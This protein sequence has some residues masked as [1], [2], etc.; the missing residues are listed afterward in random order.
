MG[1]EGEDMGEAGSQFERSG[2]E[3]IVKLEEPAGREDL[4]SV[5]Y[6]NVS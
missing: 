5:M 1:E 3:D 2:M 4:M 6:S